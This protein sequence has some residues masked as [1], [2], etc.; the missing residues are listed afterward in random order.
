MVHAYCRVNPECSEVAEVQAII[1]ELGRN[2]EG[3]CK[4]NQQNFKQVGISH[5]SIK[6]QGL[7]SLEK[8]GLSLTIFKID[9]RNFP[10]KFDI[11]KSSWSIVYIDGFQVLIS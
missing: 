6:H 4:V 3:G 8:E 9:Q 11:V 5:S 2:L 10:Q 1:A 7:L